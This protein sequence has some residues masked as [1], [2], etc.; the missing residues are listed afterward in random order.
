MQKTSED[1][2]TRLGEC[3]AGR[4]GAQHQCTDAEGMIMEQPAE[5]LLKQETHTLHKSP[6]IFLGGSVGKDPPAS[7]GDTGSVPGQGGSHTLG[8]S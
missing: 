3:S 7:V 1:L 2:S 6:E 8:S 4:E 5:T